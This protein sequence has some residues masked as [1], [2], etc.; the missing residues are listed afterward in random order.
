MRRPQQRE[1]F[2]QR[3]GVLEQDV[4]AEMVLLG[5]HDDARCPAECAVEA[6]DPVR[7][8][9]RNAGPKEVVPVERQHDVHFRPGI[10]R[11][12]DEYQV[13]AAGSRCVHDRL[14]QARQ[15]F[16]DRRVHRGHEPRREPGLGTTGRIDH[17]AG[18]DQDVRHREHAQDF[19][20][21]GNHVLEQ[22]HLPPHRRDVPG[23]ARTERTGS[24]IALHGA[25]GFAQQQCGFAHRRVIPA[26]ERNRPRGEPCRDLLRQPPRLRRIAGEHRQRRRIDARVRILR[27]RIRRQILVAGARGQGADAPVRL[28]AVRT[29]QRTGEGV[30]RQ[31]PAQAQD[32]GEQRRLLGGRFAEP[33]PCRG[34][35]PFTLVQPRLRFVQQRAC[36]PAGAGTGV[37]KRAPVEKLRVAGTGNDPLAEHIAGI[38][39]RAALEVAA[40]LVDARA[41]DPCASVICARK[42]LTLIS[43]RIAGGNRSMSAA[44]CF[45]SAAFPGEPASADA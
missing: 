8:A 39:R 26:V 5:G 12:L 31:P 42:R 17:V 11:R 16:A 13:G 30:L 2:E 40:D 29:L 35:S 25:V 28:A 24:G 15:A 45:S 23:I 9:D 37:R 20:R 41:Q 36:A 7:A 19:A 14:V 33:R 6:V 4:V 32:V 18:E 27:Q 38:P 43:P 10:E 34:P 1:A 22:Q 3:G 21:L 44:A